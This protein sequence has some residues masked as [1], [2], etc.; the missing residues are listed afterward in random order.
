MVIR[1]SFIATT[2]I[3][4]L[5]G[6]VTTQLAS[7]TPESLKSVSN[8]GL[9]YRYH[10]V[11]VKSKREN[12]GA[13]TFG[14][15]LSEEE[16]NNLEQELLRRGLS[17]HDL[18]LARESKVK[19]GMSD[20][21]M[22]AALGQPLRHNVSENS[23]GTNIQWIFSRGFEK[24]H[25]YVY[26]E[27]GV[28]TSIQSEHE[29]FKNSWNNNI[30]TQVEARVGETYNKTT[31]ESDERSI[32]RQKTE[33]RLEG[34]ENDTDLTYSNNI[35]NTLNRAWKEP[36]GISAHHQ[37]TVQ[38]VIDKDGV[39]TSWKVVRNSKNEAFNKSVAQVFDKVK[40]VDTPPTPQEYHLSVTFETQ[41]EE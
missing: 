22:L 25:L 39:I 6:C 40:K 17:Q 8:V 13:L 1:N 41:V 38:V 2:C 34:R 4:L 32:N 18:D 33:T 3:F 10:C 30:Q 11:I 29:D 23:S 7:Y 14:Q 20:L 31:D 27:N 12:A 28:V 21:A 19:V 24:P 5:A 36:V 35:F 37:A 16:F 15:I 26:T 9:A